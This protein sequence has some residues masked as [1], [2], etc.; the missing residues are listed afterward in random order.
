MNLW[1]IKGDSWDQTLLSIATDGTKGGV[2]GLA[3][4]LGGVEHVYGRNLGAVSK[5]F[6]ERFG[7]N[8]GMY[9]SFLL[10]QLC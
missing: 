9:L 2:S 8:P 10:C 3:A 7:F 6:V 5:W 1:D 4:K